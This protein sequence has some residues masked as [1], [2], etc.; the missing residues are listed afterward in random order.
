MCIRDRFTATTRRTA[1]CVSQ[2]QTEPVWRYFFTHKHTIPA[3]ATFGSYH[4]MELFYVFNNWENAT[5]GSGI[6]FK[7]QDDSVQQ[8]MLNYWV[9]FANTGNPNGAGL[10]NWPEYQSAGDCYLNIKA[11]PTGTNCGLRTAQSD[12]WDDASGFTGCSGSV[13]TQAV[14]N[15]TGL[16]VY[17]N[18][19]DGWI[20]LQVLLPNEPLSICLYDAMGRR[21]IS[22]INSLQVDLSPFPA[23]I[24]LLTME[25]KGYVWRSKIL[26]Q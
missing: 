24:Y 10:A 3:L 11:T 22:A 14:I 7:P 4:G 1:Q 15:E 9:N 12:L 13:G 17:P 25:Q 23:G 8:V 2:N 16:L 19:T 18:P 21:L 6:L 26:K 20:N 5:L